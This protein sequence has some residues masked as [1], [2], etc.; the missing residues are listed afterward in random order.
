MRHC[1]KC[2]GTNTRAWYFRHAHM[3]STMEC[4]DCGYV[5]D[6]PPERPSPP[7]EVG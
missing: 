4:L 6:V 7:Q 1:P 5:G 3:R 2:G